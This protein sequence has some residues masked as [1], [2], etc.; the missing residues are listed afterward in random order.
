LWGGCF[1]LEEGKGEES[2]GNFPELGGKGR[3]GGGL[4][5]KIAPEITMRSSAEL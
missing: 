2:G 3:I 4:K 1:T 5:R